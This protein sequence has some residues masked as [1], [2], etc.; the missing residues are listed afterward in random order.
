MVAHL[1]DTVVVKPQKKAVAIDVVIP[2]SGSKEE[3]EKT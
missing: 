3:K 2:T 1:L